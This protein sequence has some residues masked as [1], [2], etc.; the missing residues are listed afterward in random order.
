MRPHHGERLT[1]SIT[2]LAAEFLERHRGEGLVTVRN[3]QINHS[4]KAA[5]VFITVYPIEAEGKALTETKFLRSELRDFLDT[6]L[7]GHSLTY[8]DFA[9]DK[10]C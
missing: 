9:L 10:R 5:T 4:G 8:V 3:V 7:R 6:R 1:A 2:R